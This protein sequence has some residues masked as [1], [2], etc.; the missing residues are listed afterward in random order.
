Y[1]PTLTA[2]GGVAFISLVGNV[3]AYNAYMAGVRLIGSQKAILYGYAEPV[4][5][6]AVSAVFLDSS[7]GIFEFFGFA[8]VFAMLAVL[9][10]G[11]KTKPA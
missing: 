11:G 4:T 5:A 6:A 9:S 3:L 7:F 2:L 8:A 1:A 10:F